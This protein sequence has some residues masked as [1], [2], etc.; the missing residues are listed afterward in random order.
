MLSQRLG[1]GGEGAVYCV[2]G[3]SSTVAKIYH[4]PPHPDKGRKLLLMSSM[5]DR[6]LLEIAAWP[7][8][9]LHADRNGAVRGLIMPRIQGGEEIHELYSPAHRKIQFPKADW[10][11]LVR[12][13]RNCAGAFGRLHKCG[14]VIGDVNQGNVFVTQQAMIHLIDCDSFQIARNG[15][16]FRC[17]VGVP[18]FTPPELQG[19]RLSK[20]VRN[21]NHDTFGLAVLIFHL[22]FMG[23]H[24]Y[25][26]RYLGKGD[27]PLEKSIS[28]HRFAYGANA[29][30]FQIA[31]PPHTM[32]LQEI[33]PYIG[34]F[35]ERAFDPLA[36][37]R[38][39][40]PSAQEWYNA[41]TKMEGELK[42]CGE[43]STHYH[44]SRACTWCRISRAGGPDFFLGLATSTT[45]VS[46]HFDV[47]SAW[48]AIE[49]VAT[50]EASYR[51]RRQR[52]EQVYSPRPLPF[53]Q[54]GSRLPQQIAGWTAVAFGSF[55]ASSLVV[56]PVLLPIGALG[57]VLFTIWWLLLRAKDPVQREQR[58]RKLRVRQVE[59]E[60]QQAKSALSAKCDEVRKQFDAHRQML[61]QLKI[62]WENSARDRQRELQAL[63][64]HVR[65]QQLRS[66]LQRQFIS[67]ARITKI[68]DVRKTTLASYGIETAAD[69]TESSVAQIPGFGPTLTEALLSWKQRCVA[70]FV[71]DP[72]Q[73]VPQ[74]VLQQV[75]IK[76]MKVRKL[77]EQQLA[78][79]PSQLEFIVRAGHSAVGQLEE[80]VL[81]KESELLQAK[82][83]VQI[84]K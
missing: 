52:V 84:G 73:G 67:S 43:E 34:D 75:D 78:Q 59:R 12:T 44:W 16:L 41:L 62:N 30:Q 1:V 3:S 66:F 23:R 37:Q 28:E 20:V 8:R 65:D 9:T 79:G 13:A 80:V 47:G 7:Q 27:L 57:T 11:F 39:S 55:M 51:T 35:F 10:R 74:V 54:R 56:V 69:I 60:L 83:D 76:Y 38:Q 81:R 6:S 68:G 70:S 22:L 31:P 19:M 29:A 82:A 25:S 32:T 49:R 50:P 53:D 58:A 21:I 77:I 5:T 15:D 33:P 46:V 40:R 26:G 18:H 4:H 72:Q 36:G 64:A 24:P 2:D 14:I 63:R 45:Q 71:F 61:L 42:Q 17:T 48:A